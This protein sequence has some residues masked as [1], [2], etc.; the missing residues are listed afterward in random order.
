MPHVI[1]FSTHSPT[2]L[3]VLKSPFYRWGNRLRVAKYFDQGAMAA[4]WQ[5]Q[6][7][8]SAVP[9]PGSNPGGSNRSRFLSACV[10]YRALHKEL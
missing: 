6:E 1:S 8:A 7:L 5:N 3:L 9:H 10:V 2:K 4:K